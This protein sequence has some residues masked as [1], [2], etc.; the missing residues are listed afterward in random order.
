[1]AACSRECMYMYCGGARGRERTAARAAAATHDG[2]FQLCSQLSFS[3][4]PKGHSN[5]R[6]GRETK[7]YRTENCTKQEAPHGG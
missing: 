5:G 3:R 1:M 4:P 7:H 2:F 6:N